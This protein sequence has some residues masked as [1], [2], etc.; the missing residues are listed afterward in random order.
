M[1][2]GCVR[3]DLLGIESK[4]IDIEVYGLSY[5]QM[6]KALKSAFKVNQVG[7]SF[8]V[9]K[10]DNEFDLTIPRRE[11]KSGSGHKGFDVQADPT[12]TF[13]EAA[14]RRDL[15]INA[16]GMRADGSIVDPF[17]GTEDLK[18][19]ILRAPTEAFCEDP[20]R[21]LRSMQFAARFGFTMEPRTVELCRRVRSE[22]STLSPERIYMEW[23]KWAAKG[24]YPSKGL[25]LL[26]QTGWIDCFPELAA[27]QGVQ[28]NPAWHPEGDAFDHTGLVCDAAA[29]LADEQQLSTQERVI[30]LFAALCHDFGKAIS[31]YQDSQGVW[32]SPLHVKKGKP[33][34]KRFLSNMK[35]PNW[36]LENV[37]PLCSNHMIYQG[38]PR[39]ENPTPSM[40]RKLSEQLEPSNI[41][42]WS[43]LCTADKIG[44]ERKKKEKN[45]S[46]VAS[47]ASSPFRFW[48]E[49]ARKMQID[50]QKPKPLLQ[51][52]DLLPWGIAAGP[53]MGEILK[54][55]W[56][57]QLDG[58]FTD[59]ESAKQWL[60]QYLETG[61]E[62]NNQGD[63]CLPD[64]SPDATVSSDA[65]G[66]EDGSIQEDADG[67]EKRSD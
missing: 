8:N 50:T 53:Q 62:A 35:P 59:A 38:V 43:L 28:Q 60:I 1:V 10:I 46:S 54:Q 56:E 19:G 44:R 34:I 49:K 18:A 39:I 7:Q 20:L 15:T 42:L 12:M 23:Y 30:L 17:H 65:D 31:T 14:S 61:K 45:A 57:A 67:S 5:E 3:D 24:K 32:R 40:L 21:V 63:S 9:L 36:L 47:F 66:P 2:G 22:F 48:L 4:D 41:N 13:S 51:G 6:S 16:I 33:I 52:R 55:A 27:L 29:Q 11:S 37:V 25:E 58:A 64:V 26:R